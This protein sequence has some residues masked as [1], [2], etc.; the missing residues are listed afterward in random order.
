M[1]NYVKLRKNPKKM[2]AQATHT[3]RTNFKKAYLTIEIAEV[4]NKGCTE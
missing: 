1:K 3:K 4:D 2:L